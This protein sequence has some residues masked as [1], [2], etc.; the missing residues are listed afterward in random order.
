MGKISQAKSLSEKGMTL[1]EGIVSKLNES[2]EVA[3]TILSKFDVFHLKTMNLF[4][5]LNVM[6]K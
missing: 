5:L 3:K 2:T 4:Q 1:I 6:K